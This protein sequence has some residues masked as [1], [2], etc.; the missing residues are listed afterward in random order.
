MGV[1]TIGVVGDDPPIRD[2]LTTFLEDEHYRVIAAGT[3]DDA[4]TLARGEVRLDA[5]LMD[6]DNGDGI[7]LCRNI[8][9]MKL[10]RR[11]PIIC[12]TG[13]D[14]PDML[15]SAF[16]AGADDFIG[17]PI[18]LV[19]LLARLKS[20]LQKT[21]YY[22][23]LERA[24]QMLRRYLSPRVADIAEEYSETGTIPPPTERQGAI[25][26]TD[27]R[28]FTALSE[29]L[30]PEQLFSSLSGHLRRQVEL[31]YK[32][33]GYVDKFNGDGIMA[34]FDGPGMVEKC[35]LCA[36]AI[37]EEATGRNPEEDKLPIGVGIHTGRVMVGN[38]GSPE[39]FD[40]SIIGATVNLAARLCGYAQP[41]TIIVSNAVKDAV[42]S[43][44][45]LMFL[46]PREVQIRGVSGMVRIFRLVVERA[47][48]AVS[49]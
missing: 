20:Q 45:G 40:Y 35:C 32:N 12:I 11:T 47:E 38:I 9:A 5:F 39:H 17:K 25:C 30:D 4:L 14:Y 6:I 21:D 31:V 10:Y 18:N 27:I 41:E 13:Q 28:G 44:A 1:Y 29:T 48:G 34:V 26:F 49:R 16:D 8:R 42:A 33:G 2:L 23:K 37:M 24:R 19:S 7:E 3:C 15:L 43:D 22:Q 36:L 46:D